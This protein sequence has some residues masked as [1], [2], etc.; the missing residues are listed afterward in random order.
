MQRGVLQRHSLS[1][2][3]QS[4]LSLGLRPVSGPELTYPR[5][6]LCVA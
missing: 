1:I 3:S 6:A 2:H 4:T 5:A